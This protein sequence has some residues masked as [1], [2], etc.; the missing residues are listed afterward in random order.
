MGRDVRRA[1]VRQPHGDPDTHRAQFRRRSQRLLTEVQQ[2]GVDT[3][4]FP[5]ISGLKVTYTCSGP[6]PVVVTECQGTGGSCGPLTPIGPADTVRIVTNDF[7]FSGGDGYTVFAKAPT[8]A[9]RRRSADRHRL[10]HRQLTGRTGGRGAVGQELTSADRGSR[11]REDAAGC[12]PARDHH[13]GGHADHQALG[14]QRGETERLG[15][16]ADVVGRVGQPGR[17]A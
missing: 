15:P 5:Q 13:T 17:P 10:R 3:G 9:A 6:S 16:L 4:R 11:T 1:A 8:C 7:M 2:P 12:L 14:D